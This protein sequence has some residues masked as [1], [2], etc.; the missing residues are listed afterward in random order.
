VPKKIAPSKVEQFVKRGMIEANSRYADLSGG[1]WVTGGTACLTASTKQAQPP[2]LSEERMSIKLPN[3]VDVHVGRRVKMRRMMLNLSQSDL[4]EKSGITFQ[5]IQKYEKGSNRV[6][7]G[8]LQEFS[9]VL[10]VPVSFFFDGSS[11]WAKLKSGPDDLTQQLLFT[12]NGIDLVKAF[13]SISDKA[14]RRSIVSMVEE[15][16]NEE[17]ASIPKQGRAGR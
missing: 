16:A 3:P 7:A 14:L 6:S 4:G 15:I 10:N 2:N 9:K 5:Q 8:R 1:E 17:A 11:N 12:R 13:M